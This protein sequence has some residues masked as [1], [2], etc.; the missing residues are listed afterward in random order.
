MKLDIQLFGGR[1]ASSSENKNKRKPS[2]SR[3]NILK[4]RKTI[5]DSVREHL[6][7]NLRRL[8]WVNDNTKVIFYDN[9][10]KL[11]QTKMSMINANSNSEYLNMTHQSM[12]FN[13]SKNEIKIYAKKKK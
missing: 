13:S 5:V 3:N 6:Q 7:D 11:K 12:T 1:G 2:E 4:G 10:V 9:D 8:N